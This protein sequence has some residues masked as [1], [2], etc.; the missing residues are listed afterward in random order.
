MAQQRQKKLPGQGRADASRRLA[1]LLVGVVQNGQEVEGAAAEGQF[2]D[3]S[4]GQIA[5]GIHP[6]E[7]KIGVRRMEGDE[8]TNVGLQPSNLFAARIKRMNQANLI[9]GAG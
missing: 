4:E 8:V 7:E 3:F 9:P 5:R 6:D 2:V 1:R